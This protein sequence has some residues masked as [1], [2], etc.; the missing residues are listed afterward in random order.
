MAPISAHILPFHPV[1]TSTFGFTLIGAAVGF[2]FPAGGAGGT[3]GAGGI[4]GT[5]GTAGLVLAAEA[6][7]ADASVPADADPADASAAVA[8]ATCGGGKGGG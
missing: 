4:A 1:F 5:A 8:F 7:G 6:F 3:G 2:A